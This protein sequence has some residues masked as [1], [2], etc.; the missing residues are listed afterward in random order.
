VPDLKVPVSLYPAF[1]GLSEETKQELFAEMVLDPTAMVRRCCNIS[2]D[3]KEQH[4]TETYVA[5]TV[6]GSMP[7]PGTDQVRHDV[8]TGASMLTGLF[9][10]DWSNAVKAAETQAKRRLTTSLTGY[11]FKGSAKEEEI[12]AAKATEPAVVETPQVNNGKAE[13]TAD[14]RP[15]TNL[16]DLMPTDLEMA[17]TAAEL[18]PL[19]TVIPTASEATL[20]HLHQEAQSLSAPTPPS[21]AEG[22][23]IKP[24]APV[25]VPAVA[26]PSFFDDEP[27]EVPGPAAVPNVPAHAAP[28][29]TEV[30][31]Q[32]TAS[33]PSTIVGTPAVPDAPTGL[34]PEPVKD[35]VI[36]DAPT[37]AV[38]TQIEYRE[39]TARCT[40]LVRE[41]LSKQK[42]SSDLLLPYLRNRFGVKDLAKANTLAWQEA[43]AELEA[44]TNIVDTIKILKGGK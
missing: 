25:T 18:V 4:I 15:D 32:P 31:P 7:I 39:F 8:G 30:A 16:R 37:S 9:G 26:Q 44:C 33:A 17:K 22:A 35:I 5:T 12:V 21:Q 42:G 34:A 41:V 27:S 23:P 3:R 11:G 36:P 40:K 14:T 19:P 24:A 29:T 2:I 6:Y 38:P 43:L 28:S 20:A 10:M 1:A 13:V